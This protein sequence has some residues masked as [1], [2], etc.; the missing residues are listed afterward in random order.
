MDE[1]W[2][3][4]QYGMKKYLKDKIARCENQRSWIEY[5]FHICN[6]FIFG[7]DEDKAYCVECNE[8]KEI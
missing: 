5:S 3:N 8:Y 1:I 6:D 2:W 4:K 7:D